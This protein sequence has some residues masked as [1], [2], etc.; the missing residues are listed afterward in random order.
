M[1]ITVRDVRNIDANQI[2]QE[3]QSNIEN[4]RK[5]KSK[6]I[7]QLFGGNINFFPF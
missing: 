6:Y 1:F 2:R 5:K 7:Q 4:Y 3:F